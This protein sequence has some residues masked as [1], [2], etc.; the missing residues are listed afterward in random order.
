MVVRLEEEVRVRLEAE[1][2]QRLQEP[3]LVRPEQG[4]QVRGP[5]RQ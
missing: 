3:V 4:Q 2:E 5:E 1:R